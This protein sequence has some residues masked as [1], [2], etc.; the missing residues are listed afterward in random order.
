[1]LP[2]KAQPNLVRLRILCTL[3][4]TTQLAAPCSTLG[5]CGLVG[6][7]IRCLAIGGL[8]LEPLEEWSPISWV[9]SC[10]LKSYWDL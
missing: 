7:V 3:R 5:K 9:T 4:Q 10:F 6:S 8:P 1:M 2:H